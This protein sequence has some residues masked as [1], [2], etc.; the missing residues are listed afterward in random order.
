SPGGVSDEKGPYNPALTIPSLNASGLNI[1][2]RFLHLILTWILRPISEHVIIRSIGYWWI[3]C[4]QNNG[5]LNL[6]LI[7]FNDI[8]NVIGKDISAREC[9]KTNHEM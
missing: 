3:G 9:P 4:F 2:D 6:A 8:T 7:M 5:C 1:H